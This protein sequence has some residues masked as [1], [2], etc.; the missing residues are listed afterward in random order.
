MDVTLDSGA[1]THVTLKDA[2]PGGAEIVPNESGLHFTGPDGGTILKHGTAVTNM[3]G[4]HGTAALKW[5]VADVSKTLQSVS[6]TTGDPEGDGDYDVL[7]NNRKAVIVPAGVVNT[8]LEQMKP[9]AEYKRR[10]NL[11]VAQVELSGFAR[12]GQP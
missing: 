7:F 11:Y 10:G 2:I 4:Q 8:I 9:V 3:K 5:S 12:Q 6:Q 1:T